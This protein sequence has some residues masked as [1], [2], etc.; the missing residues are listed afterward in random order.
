MGFK[1]IHFS[2]PFPLIFIL[3]SKRNPHLP[4]SYCSTVLPRQPPFFTER[5]IVDY[6]RWRETKFFQMQYREEKGNER[7][8]GAGAREPDSFCSVMSPAQQEILAFHICSFEMWLLQGVPGRWLLPVKIKKMHT[9][10]SKAYKASRKTSKAQR[11]R[12][13]VFSSGRGF[14]E[15]TI[16]LRQ[17]LWGPLAYCD[18][19][20][21]TSMYCTHIGPVVSSGFYTELLIIH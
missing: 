6:C 18:L 15:T 9:V 14:G 3:W 5:F 2:V 4:L 10:K 20:V 12:R 8:R 17:N 16:T 21:K 11:N 13:G 7:G 19:T 1:Q